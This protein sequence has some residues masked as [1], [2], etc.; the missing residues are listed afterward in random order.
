M[1]VL[2]ADDSPVHRK[3]LDHLL[4]GWGYDVQ[5]AND[6]SEAL[7]ILEGDSSLRLAIV[8]GAMPGLTGPEI[9][10]AIRTGSRPV[11]PEN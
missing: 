10:K 9:C 6:G 11:I 4:V 2:V 3:L 1:K 5:L 8:D 7:A